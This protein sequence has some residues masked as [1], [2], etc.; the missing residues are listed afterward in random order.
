[1]LISCSWHHTFKRMYQSDQP[2]PCQH[3]P[4]LPQAGCQVT[5]FRSLST[6]PSLPVLSKVV[7]ASVAMLR[8]ESEMSASMSMLQLVT[9]MGWVIA[10][11]FSVRTAANLHNMQGKHQRSACSAAVSTDAGRQS[12]VQSTASWRSHGQQ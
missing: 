12:Q 11:L 10:T 6:L 1:M 9:A 5:C 7:M 4:A 8:L 3:Q 2:L